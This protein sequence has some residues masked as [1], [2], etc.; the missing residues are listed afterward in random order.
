MGQKMLVGEHADMANGGVRIL[1]LLSRHLRFVWL[2]LVQF[3]LLTLMHLPLLFIGAL[4]L[5]CYILADDSQFKSFPCA[6][7]NCHRI[8]KS[9]A[10][11]TQQW[12]ATHRELTPASEPDPE[13]QFTT[14]LHPVLN[15]EL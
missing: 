15:G 8:Y 9:T 4:L 7:P 2:T 5:C 13:T 12:N 10:G 3:S 6:H 1:G 14:H 11:R